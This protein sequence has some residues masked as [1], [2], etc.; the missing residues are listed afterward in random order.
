MAA[1]ACKRNDRT[2]YASQPRKLK[3]NYKKKKSQ[4]KRFLMW[5]KNGEASWWDY[6][7]PHTHIKLL[8]MKLQKNN[9]L[10]VV[11]VFTY[12]N[13]PLHFDLFLLLVLLR[14]RNKSTSFFFSL[15]FKTH[16]E[17]WNKGKL[18]LMWWKITTA[19]LLQKLH[20]RVCMWKTTSIWKAKKKKEE[21][22]VF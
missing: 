22:D 11:V 18:W 5:G 21:R 3:L 20:M 17:N 9:R 6:L 7:H 19:K 12:S 15:L 16:V 14:H 10:W 13:S 8:C 2:D 1:Q 4:V